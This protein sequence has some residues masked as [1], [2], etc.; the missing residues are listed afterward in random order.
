MSGNVLKIL[1][2]PHTESYYAE[3]IPNRDSG[4]DVYVSEDLDVELTGSPFS[5]VYTVHSD[6]RCELLVDGEAS[7]FLLMPRSSIHKAHVLMANSTGLID[8][9]YRGELLGKVYATRDT[10]IKKGHRLFQI[11]APNLKPIK[12]ELV[13]SLSSTERGEGG[14]GSTGV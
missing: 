13:D 4:L 1:R 7:G 8:S 6:L 2:T 5:E 12:V 3:H 11:V 14:F 9:P 10:N